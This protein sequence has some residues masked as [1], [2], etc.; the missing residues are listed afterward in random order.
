MPTIETRIKEL[1]HFYVRTNYEK[2]LGE[3]SIQSIPTSEILAVMKELYTERKEH[4]KGFIRDSLKQMMDTEYP[5]DLA[6]LN[7]LVS[8]FEDDELCINRLVM[9]IEVHQQG[10]NGGTYDY[11]K[12]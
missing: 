3:H 4:L 9:E 1:I 5:G 7:I 12:L 2:Y 6:I 8:V 10:V 11:R